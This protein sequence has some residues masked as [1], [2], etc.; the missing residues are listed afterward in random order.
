MKRRDEII[1]TALKMFN[2]S[3]IHNVGVR[4]IAR[5]LSISVGNL[6]YHFPRKED[7][8]AEILV[9]LR[10]RNTVQ[11]EIFFSGEPTLFAYLTLMRGV[12]LNQYNFRGV[13]ISPLDIKKIYQ[14]LFDYEK[15]EKERK[16]MQKDIF[17]RL[18]KAGELTLNEKG[19]DFMVS[20]ISLFS[21]FWIQ[22]AFL[23]YENLSREAVV[24]KYLWTLSQQLAIFA[25]P[26]GMEGIE[27]FF[28]E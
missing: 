23:S 12:F 25:T 24:E 5:S 17:Q 1:L 3:G 6:S 9:H 26:D 20:F 16:A 19:S 18:T 27:L 28:A 21:R 15:V 7:I 4:E 11:Y 2:E 8:V 10:A 14:N 22:E 13:V